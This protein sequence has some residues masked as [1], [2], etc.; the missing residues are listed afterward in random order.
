MLSPVFNPFDGALQQKRCRRDRNLLGIDNEFC[1]KSAAN[2]GRHDAD[3]I[4]VDAEH[5]HDEIA[6]F[7]GEPSAHMTPLWRPEST[8]KYSAAAGCL[9]TP[10]AVG[11]TSGLGVNR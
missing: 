5:L 8:L 4:F 7:V 6:S 11:W 9:E 3:A 10:A 2:V 1:A